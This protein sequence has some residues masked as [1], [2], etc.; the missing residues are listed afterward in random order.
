MRRYE[1]LKCFLNSPLPDLFSLLKSNHS[2]V[3]IASQ[4]AAWLLALLSTGVGVPG[5]YPAP[6][7]PRLRARPPLCRVRRRSAAVITGITSAR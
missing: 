2:H 7:P 5:F 4:R 6:T 3:M 1:N